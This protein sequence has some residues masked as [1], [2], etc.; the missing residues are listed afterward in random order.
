MRNS[1]EKAIKRITEGA[2]T[3][4]NP[5]TRALF[6][7][8]VLDKVKAGGEKIIVHDVSDYIKVSCKLKSFDIDSIDDGFIYNSLCAGEIESKLWLQLFKTAYC[9]YDIP[10]FANDR[11]KYQFLIYESDYTLYREFKNGTRKPEEMIYIWYE[12]GTRTFHSIFK[13]ARSTVYI[14]ML[15][16]AFYNDRMP[17][18]FSKDVPKDLAEYLYDNNITDIAEQISDRLIEG[19]FEINIDKFNN[20]NYINARKFFIW[21]LNSISPYGY[22]AKCSLYRI[23]VLDHENFRPVFIKGG[24]P[25]LY[26]IFDEMPKHDI[27]MFIPNGENFSTFNTE[28]VVMLD[29]TLLVNE[30][31]RKCL[32]KYMWYGTG[33][34][35]RRVSVFHTIIKIVNKLLPDKNHECT[36][37]DSAF[38]ASIKTLIKSE[39]ANPQTASTIICRFSTFFSF[40]EIRGLLPVDKHCFL[41]LSS[42]HTERDHLTEGVPPEDIKRIAEELDRRKYSSLRDMAMYTVFHLN[43][44]TE[45]RISQIM[46]LDIDCVKESMKKGEYYIYSGTKVSGGTPI[47]QP[48]AKIVKRIIDEY[49]EYTADLREKCENPNMKLKIFITQDAHSGIFYQFDR[50]DYQKALSNICKNIGIRVYRSRNIRTTYITNAKEYV[51]KNGISDATLLAISNHKS[52]DTVN[53]HYIEEK[54]RDSLQATYNVI[55]GDIDIKGIVAQDKDT[56]T[57]TRGASVENE[58]GYCQ[59][60]ECDSTGPLPCLLCRHFATTVDRIPYF[61]SCI[62][63]LDEKIANARCP[64][65]VEDAINIKRLYVRYLEALI[66]LKEKSNA[67]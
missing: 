1:F 11:Y 56:I 22:T 43:L 58:C 50:N 61:K 12:N 35:N 37:I 33:T 63:M 40:I 20:N 66:N 59:N 36:R 24:R 14:S 6:L 31:L 8:M 2:K 7:E 44:N 60:E 38:C 42:N 19:F 23:H 62:E 41:Y 53:S 27:W 57:T 9:K 18:T 25:V 17:T 30:Q 39:Y 55:I 47:E 10:L 67:I 32:K 4:E 46:G 5:K 52:M 15:I 64:H 48:C 26:N 65:D 54:I 29:F 49:L 3:I 21:V 45:F 28:N 13:P 34:I 16:S 51:M